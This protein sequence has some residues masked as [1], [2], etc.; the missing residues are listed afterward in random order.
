MQIDVAINTETNVIVM[1]A[2]QLEIKSA[3]VGDV[4]GSPSLD[5]ENQL[6]TITFP[7]NLSVGDHKLE[8][9]YSGT[10]N[11]ELAGFYRTKGKF[12]YMI[13][14]ISRHNFSKKVYLLTL[15]EVNS[16]GEINW[17]LV[18]QFEAC[19][20]RRALPCW[21]EPDRKAKFQVKLTIPKGSI[22]DTDL[23]ISIFESSLIEKKV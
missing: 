19:D 22:L 16:E 23:S 18:T 13:Y 5:L 9:E 7:S 21:D 11:D 1:N 2:H 10:L 6:L 15:K 20:A 3:K 4:I 17:A 12:Q 14:C 8:I